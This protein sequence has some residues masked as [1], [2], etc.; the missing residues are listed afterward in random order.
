M[1]KEVQDRMLFD[2]QA[3]SL[4]SFIIEKAGMD[5]ARALVQASRD[6]Q[7]LREMLIRPD[8]LGTDMEKLES[9]WQTWLKTQKGD[10][11]G[12]RIMVGPGNRPP[13][14]PSNN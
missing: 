10:P 12:M 7:D 13:G 11:G 9:D 1:P 8:F 3:A 4:F 5:K 2:A 6:K 14:A